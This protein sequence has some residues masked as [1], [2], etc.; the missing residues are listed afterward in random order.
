M[1]PIAS[2]NVAVE[3]DCD[4]AIAARLLLDLEIE[5][6]IH[7]M[8][9]AGGL[10]SRLPNYNA[11]ARHATWFVLRDL[12]RHD[13]APRLIATLLPERSP[14]LCLR[15]AVRESE[16]WILADRER[17]AAWLGVSE[18]RMPRDPDALADPKQELI[19]LARQSRRRHVKDDLV[20]KTGSTARIGPGYV[21]SFVGFVAQH[22]RPEIAART[23]DSLA[24]CLRALQKLRHPPQV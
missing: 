14:G 11:A 24:R 7:V 18:A 20:P 8:H 23:S 12:D 2:I 9:G 21:G 1:S 3:G 4:R 15:I 6:R 10:D 13:C 5:A 17:A 16:A 19:N 22:W